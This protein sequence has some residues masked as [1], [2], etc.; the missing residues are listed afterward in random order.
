MR[1][2]S[3]WKGKPKKEADVLN[4]DPVPPERQAHEQVW[5]R[6]ITVLGRDEVIRRLVA[7]S[8]YR[9]GRTG[10]SGFERWN[11]LIEG[12]IKALAQDISRRSEYPWAATEPVD[13]DPAP[14]SRRR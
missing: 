6:E 5:N 11:R 1:L 10:P 4:S 2:L 14:A 8:D 13:S 7:L 3:R 12:D 9:N